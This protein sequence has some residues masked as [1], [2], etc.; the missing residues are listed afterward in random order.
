M[1]INNYCQWQRATLIICIISTDVDECSTSNGGCDQVCTNAIG[2]FNC[3]CNEGFSLN[4]DGI[5][6][7]G[8]FK[9]L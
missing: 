2:S 5:T 4:A 3:S 6:C 8:E 9:V 7:D 1:H